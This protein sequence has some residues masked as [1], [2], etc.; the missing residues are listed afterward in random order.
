MQTATGLQAL[1]TLIFQLQLV[2][3]KHL[4]FR[5]FPMSHTSFSARDCK[6]ALREAPRLAFMV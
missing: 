1:D 3:S 4:T 6:I 2:H 5:P